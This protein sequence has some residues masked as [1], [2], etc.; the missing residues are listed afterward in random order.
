ML[1]IQESNTSDTE[2]KNKPTSEN[3]KIKIDD[4]N[5]LKPPPYSKAKQALTATT[6]DS[7]NPKDKKV[8][9]DIN[10]PNNAIRPAV[11]HSI[12]KQ[13]HKSDIIKEPVQNIISSKH[14]NISLNKSRTKFHKNSS[15]DKHMGYKPVPNK[16]IQNKPTSSPMTIKTIDPIAG[17][18]SNNYT[19]KD[20]NKAY[21][22]EDN[23]KPQA[24]KIPALANFAVNKTIPFLA[25]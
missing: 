7:S 19:A 5:P 22:I 4:K 21:K 9:T 1:D 14:Q 6:F 16:P 17:I 13:T 20:D 10:D 12:D 23:P 15:A 24:N 25:G 11:V 8:H 18:V 3:S 2:L